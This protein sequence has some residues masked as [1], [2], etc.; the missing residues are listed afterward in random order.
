MIK[1]Y[2]ASSCRI[3]CLCLAEHLASADRSMETYV[4][5]KMTE[6]NCLSHSEFFQKSFGSINRSGCMN[7]Q[8]V[9]EGKYA[10]HVRH[11]Q[12]Q[13]AWQPH[14]VTPCSSP[15]FTLT[16]PTSQF[17]I[18]SPHHQLMGADRQ[19][20]VLFSACRS[21]FF[22]VSGI[23]INSLG[24]DRLQK[25]IL[26]MFECFSSSQYGLVLLLL[27]STLFFLEEG[28]GKTIA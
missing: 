3:S 9:E 5:A 15:P 7:L 27:V 16:S 24:L 12:L 25:S 23:F 8:L 18:S 1:D 20:D 2:L 11:S 28:E 13:G 22:W 10:V 14:S 6:I 4:L 17:I 19:V 21:L 26:V